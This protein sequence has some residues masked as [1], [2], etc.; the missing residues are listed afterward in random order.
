MSL[1]IKSNRTNEKFRRGRESA[2]HLIK[3][4]RCRLGLKQKDIAAKIGVE[5][6]SFISQIETGTSRVP[7]ELMGKMAE[8]LE[9][10]P[11]QL[12]RT[13]LKHYDPTLY[14]WLFF[15]DRVE[16]L[17]RPDLLWLELKENNQE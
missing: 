5:Y 2:G 15:Y 3:R 12:A 13:L 9:V 1:A 11:Q 8:A 17:D 7:T 6:Y 14:R 10:D 16:D 4:L